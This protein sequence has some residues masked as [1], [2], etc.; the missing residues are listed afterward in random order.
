MSHLAILISDGF[1]G[2]PLLGLQLHTVLV[3]HGLVLG[4]GDGAIF[5][6]VC[7][8]E[9]VTKGWGGKL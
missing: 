4:E 9:Q 5:G 3:A 2:I 7:F 1:K 8:V 6:H